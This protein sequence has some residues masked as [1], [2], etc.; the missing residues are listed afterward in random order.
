MACATA[1]N[2]VLIEVGVS[3]NGN[4]VA[5]PMSYR[6]VSDTSAIFFP[7]NIVW[8][9]QPEVA[10]MVSDSYSIIIAPP[11]PGEYT[12]ET[13]LTVE[14]MTEPFTGTFNIV[15]QE[16]QILQPSEEP[17]TEPEASPVS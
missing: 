3:I 8:D 11:Q 9:V 1:S 16:P 15:E 6:T 14:G 10:G 17:A 13:S 5:E 7:E 2:D 4:E 12:I